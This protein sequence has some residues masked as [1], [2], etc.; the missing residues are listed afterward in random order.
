MY[1]D[2]ISDSMDAAIKET[3]R[4]REIQLSYNEKNG[5][6]PKMQQSHFQKKTVNL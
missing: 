5:I 6:T 3:N 1:A 4:R 2:T